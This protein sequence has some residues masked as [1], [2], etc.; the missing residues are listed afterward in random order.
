MKAMSEGG[1]VAKLS[2]ALSL[3]ERRS[4]LG[5]SATVSSATFRN[6]DDILAHVSKLPRVPDRTINWAQFG[7]HVAWFD[8]PVAYEYISHLDGREIS[9]TKAARLKKSVT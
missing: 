2:N 7:Q 8:E 9:A 6:L 5:Q 1:L 3:R 4:K